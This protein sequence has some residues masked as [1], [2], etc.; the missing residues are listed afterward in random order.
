MNIDPESAT[1]ALP[2]GAGG[3]ASVGPAPNAAPYLSPVPF[4]GTTGRN[5]GRMPG[6]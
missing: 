4:G 2:G 3:G 5:G 6:S 1:L